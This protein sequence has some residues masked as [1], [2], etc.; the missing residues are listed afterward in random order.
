MGRCQRSA[1]AMTVGFIGLG[2]QGA[3]MA[4]AIADKGFDLYV[5]ARRPD[6]YRALDGSPHTVADSPA[7]LAAHADIIALCLRDD[8]D[9][10][11][12]LDDQ[13]LL[14]ALRPGTVVVNHGTG[15][16]QENQRLAEHVATAGASFLDAP[17][18]GGRPG[19]EA[20]M[21]TTFVGGDP[22]SYARLEPIAAG[23][24]R[25]VRLLGPVGSGQTVKLI[26]NALNFANLKN[27]TDA[28]AIA[29]ALRIDLSVLG[30]VLATSTGNSASLQYAL[31]MHDQPA[32]EHLG[33]LMRKDLEHF[34]E[35]VARNGVDVTSLY[36][37]ARQGID[38]ALAAGQVHV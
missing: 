19:A 3:P 32:P 11:A 38:S 22:V 10:W 6:S 23:F 21:L 16:P 13:G 5:W 24:S 18:S 20:R 36:Q 34:A 31:A 4:R 27:A 28:I 9:I 25:T 1:E 15:D 12:L 2:D 7:D 29:Q 37:R 8:A 30:E 35:A 26:N 17:V 33:T 14:A